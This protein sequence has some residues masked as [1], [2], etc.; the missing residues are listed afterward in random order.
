MKPNTSLM[1]KRTR[2]S[3]LTSSFF[4]DGT[5]IR[6]TLPKKHTPFMVKLL[7]WLNGWTSRLTRMNTTTWAIL[8]R[9]TVRRFM[10]M[11]DLSL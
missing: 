7:Q 3:R 8:L 1:T 11:N 2:I 6:I 9:L 10:N 4:P 5:P